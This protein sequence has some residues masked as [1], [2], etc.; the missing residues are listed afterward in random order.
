MVKFHFF[1]AKAARSP[2]DSLL[3]ILIYNPLN[4]MPE[5]LQLTWFVHPLVFRL[6]WPYPVTMKLTALIAACL[7]PR[8]LWR[9][10]SVHPLVSR[11]EWP[12][13]V[14]MKLTVLIAAC[15]LVACDVISVFTL[16][17]PDSSDPIQWPWSWPFWSPLVFSWPASTRPLSPKPRL[18]LFWLT[19]TNHA[20]SNSTVPAWGC[21]G[22]TPKIQVVWY[23]ME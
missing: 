17:F 22:V 19:M 6:E 9:D 18:T 4:N 2:R 7:D 23:K 14:T 13:P 16:W 15:L 11:L 20:T 1:P 8:G 21:H 5:V 3:T 10:F 12:Y